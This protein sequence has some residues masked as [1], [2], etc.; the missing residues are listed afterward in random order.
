[1]QYTDRKR[2]SKRIVAILVVSVGGVI[3]E[4]INQIL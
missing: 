2:E 4:Q 3:R 1:M